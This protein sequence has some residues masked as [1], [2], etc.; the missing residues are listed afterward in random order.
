VDVVN[1]VVFQLI[2]KGKVPRP[3]IGILVLYEEAAASLGVVGVVI[4]RVVPGSEADRAGLEGIDYRNRRL[5]DVIVAADDRNVSN[6]DEFLRILQDFEIDQTI[7]L[8][9]LR[10]NQVRKVQVKVMDIS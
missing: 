3:G 5:G 6:M 7:I 10:V 9:V 1:Q 2:T 4:E 8:D